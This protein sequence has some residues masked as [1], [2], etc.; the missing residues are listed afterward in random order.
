[1][2]W[3]LADRILELLRLTN[4]EQTSAM[5]GY[6]I[7]RWMWSECDSSR[8]LCPVRMMTDVILQFKSRSLT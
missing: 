7:G 4:M 8:V 6:M 1:M 2:A 3:V 5:L